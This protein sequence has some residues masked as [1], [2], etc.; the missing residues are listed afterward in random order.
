MRR[1]HEKSTGII[2]MGDM[3][4]ILKKVINIIARNREKLVSVMMKLLV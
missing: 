4:F 2:S 3:L 1:L